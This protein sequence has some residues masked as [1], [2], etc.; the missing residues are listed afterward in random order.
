MSNLIEIYRWELINRIWY[1]F[2]SRGYVADGMI[3]DGGY[4]GWF[5][6]KADSG[7]KVGWQQIDGK[8]YY[9]NERSDGFKGMMYADTVTPD[10][11][12]VDGSGAWVQ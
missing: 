11:Y 1:A 2:D 5:Y 7:M 6:V 9:F 3:Y 10:G 8:W 12:E 4:G